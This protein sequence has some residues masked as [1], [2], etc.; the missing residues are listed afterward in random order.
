MAVKHLYI[1]SSNPIKVYIDN[2]NCVRW[3][4]STTTKGLRHMTIRENATR[5]SVQDETTSIHHIRCVL[6]LAEIFTKEV[7]KSNTS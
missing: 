1:P 4:K 5:E 6:N 2:N 7:R 3:N